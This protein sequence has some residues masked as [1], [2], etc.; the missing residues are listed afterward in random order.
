MLYRRQLY[1]LDKLSFGGSHKE[2]RKCESVRELKIIY[3]MKILNYMNCIHD[4]KINN[5]ATRNLQHDI[6]DSSKHT[7][8]INIHYSPILYG[9]MKTHRGKAKFKNF[10][11]LL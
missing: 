3:D 5:I 4:N 7:K 11:I 10:I 6:L 9:C 1:D 8:N 2:W